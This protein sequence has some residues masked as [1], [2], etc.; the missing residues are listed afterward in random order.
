MT[1]EGRHES[2]QYMDTHTGKRGGPSVC[3]RVVVCWLV[4]AA[5]DGWMDGWESEE[6][7]SCLPC[8]PG[9]LLH[10]PSLMCPWVGVG[11]GGCV[12]VMAFV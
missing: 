2:R 8:S 11:V 3:V 12:G 4:G 1:H 5:M 7:P 10:A 9:S 6:G